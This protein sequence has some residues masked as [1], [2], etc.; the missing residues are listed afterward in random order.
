MAG[1]WV[2]HI[3]VND[4]AEYMDYV[5]GSTQVVAQYVASSSPEGAGTRRRRDEATRAM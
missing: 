4:E 2:A 3:D 1:Y 5:Q